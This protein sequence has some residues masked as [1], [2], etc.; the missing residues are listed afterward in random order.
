M[1]LQMALFHS[2]YGWVIVH[3]PGGSVV[4]NLP[5]NTGNAGLVPELGRFFEVGNDNPTTVFLP[6]KFYGRVR[7]K[8]TGLQSRG[9]QRI[10]RDWAHI[11]IEVVI[12]PS[13]YQWT[14]KLLLCLG[15]CKQCCCE[16]WGACIFLESSFFLCIYAQEWDCWIIW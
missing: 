5:G 14:V 8:P 15:H 10:G 11:H 7:E 6:R 16:H 12:Y 4:K 1:F 13:V 3:F 2:F 9:S